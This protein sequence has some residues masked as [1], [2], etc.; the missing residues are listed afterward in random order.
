MDQG[1][2]L[3]PSCF[4]LLRGRCRETVLGPGFPPFPSA[5]PRSACL[6]PAGPRFPA[7]VS[8]FRA[9]CRRSRRCTARWR[10]THSAWPG[11]AHVQRLPSC[12]TGERSRGS[13]RVGR[14]P[15]LCG[16]G[17]AR[18]AAGVPAGPRVCAAPAAVPGTPAAVSW[19]ESGITRIHILS[20][21]C[22][23]NLLLRASRP[24][25]LN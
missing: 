13:H 9:R 12:V 20:K 25:D 4:P 18:G 8:P 15:G 21:N 3:T 17:A 5:G 22:M 6:S 24:G 2:A 14:V 11:T 7:A 1:P 19:L 23:P 16:A 10:G